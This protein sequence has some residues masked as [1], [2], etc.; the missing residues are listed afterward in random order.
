MSNRCCHSY[1]MDCTHD[2]VRVGFEAAGPATAVTRLHVDA[3][4]WALGLA[5]FFLG[6]SDEV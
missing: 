3:V 6:R 4:F 5:F 1:G 2:S